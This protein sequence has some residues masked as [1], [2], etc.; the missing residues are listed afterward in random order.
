MGSYIRIHT[1]QKCGRIVFKHNV[2]TK[3]II[4]PDRV[5]ALPLRHGQQFRALCKKCKI[6]VSL[7]DWNPLSVEK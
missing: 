5:I 4:M 3:E 6:Y 1:C 7:P 2:R